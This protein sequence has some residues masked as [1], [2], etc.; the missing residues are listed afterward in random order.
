MEKP[1]ARQRKVWK[2]IAARRELTRRRAYRIRE[3]ERRRFLDAA[4]EL[5]KEEHAD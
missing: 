4:E 5:G 3:E 2:G 1:K